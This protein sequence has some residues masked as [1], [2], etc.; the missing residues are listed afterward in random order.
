[1]EK[2]LPIL[3]KEIRNC[4]LNVGLTQEQLAQISETHVNYVGMVERGKINPSFLFLFKICTALQ[5]SCSDLVKEVE[6]AST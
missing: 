1:M 6:N 4:R 5:I 3:G 2:L